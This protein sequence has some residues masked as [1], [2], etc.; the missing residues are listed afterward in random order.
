[1]NVGKCFIRKDEKKKYVK[2][3]I[4]FNEIRCDQS[5]LMHV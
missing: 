3:Y 4:P 5:S 1:M 2:K